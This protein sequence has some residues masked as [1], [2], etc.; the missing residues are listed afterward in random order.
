VC[1][2]PKPSLGEWNF[3]S[4]ILKDQ[5]GSPGPPMCAR[6][7]EVPITPPPSVSSIVSM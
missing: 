6:T 7:C 2:V 3:F 4:L 1:V 5:L